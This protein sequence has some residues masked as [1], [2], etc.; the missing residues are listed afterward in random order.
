M[1]NKV[2]RKSCGAIGVFDSG[3][4]GISVL[5]ELVKILPN[6]DYIYFGDNK[7]APY[8]TRTDRDVLNKTIKAI[9]VFLGHNVKIIVIACN[10]VSVSFSMIL[11]KYCPV[12]I[13]FTFPPQETTLNVSGNTLLLA[14]TKTVEKLKKINNIKYYRA[15]KLV[16]AVENY[17]KYGEKIDFKSVIPFNEKLFSNVILGC[18]HYSLVK[19][20]IYDH[21][22]PQYFFRGEV[23]TA[24]MV[25]KYLNNQKKPEN[26]R[27]NSI[28]FIDDYAEENAL[29]FKKVVKLPQK[30]DIKIEKKL[31]N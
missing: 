9:D 17:G 26:Y 6:E 5:C 22:K 2:L 31:K 20:L 21:L 8:G 3:F 25:K 16:R 1:Q 18:T 27:R 13:F 29:F 23:N 4:G 19:N 7:N 11:K 12:P 30:Y 15:D 10:T 28:F 14:T 24:Q